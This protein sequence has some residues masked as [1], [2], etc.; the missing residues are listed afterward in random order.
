L[1]PLVLPLFR[2]PLIALRSASGSASRL[3][4]LELRKD[5]I[6]GA[7]REAGFDLRTGK[8]EQADYDQQIV[9]LK[10]EAVGVVGEIEQLKVD[11]PQGS[12]T[13]EQAIADLREGDVSATE[14]P[15]QGNVAPSFCTQCGQPA[16]EDDLFCPRCGTGL[17]RDR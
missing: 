17:E 9:L 8:I 6:Y 12:K 14:V 10:S 2:P 3:R 7:I 4:A 11:P 16:G 15:D 5:T 13:V 1:I